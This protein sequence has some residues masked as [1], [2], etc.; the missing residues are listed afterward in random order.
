MLEDTKEN[1]SIKD[2]DCINIKVMVM[3]AGMMKALMFSP[4]LIQIGNLIPCV[5]YVSYDTL[6]RYKSA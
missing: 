5:L 6:K 2:S 1:S 4:F 3:P